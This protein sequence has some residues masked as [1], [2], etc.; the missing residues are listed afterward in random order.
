LYILGFLFIY[1][2]DEDQRLQDSQPSKSVLNKLI[3]QV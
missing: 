3:S 2:L 1:L